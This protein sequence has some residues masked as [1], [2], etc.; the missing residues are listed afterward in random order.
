MAI[1]LPKKIQSKIFIQRK[2]LDSSF[3]TY[4]WIKQFCQDLVGFGEYFLVLVG[5]LNVL[6]EWGLE[7][8]TYFLH[9]SHKKTLRF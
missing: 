6:M 1:E 3:E 4:A 8:F 9:Q 7:K 2:K 5:T